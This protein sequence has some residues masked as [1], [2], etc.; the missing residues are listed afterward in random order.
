MV[1]STSSRLRDIYAVSLKESVRNMLARQIGGVRR[2]SYTVP[3]LGRLAKS[4]ER[5]RQCPQP[6]TTNCPLRSLGRL[7]VHRGTIAHESAYSSWTGL[8]S[9]TSGDDDADNGF[10]DKAKGT[11]NLKTKTPEKNRLLKGK[12]RRRRPKTEHSIRASIC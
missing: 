10:E 11:Q 7:E 2:K 3:W 5:A 9:Q 8:Q 4:E 12:N 6:N 1:Y